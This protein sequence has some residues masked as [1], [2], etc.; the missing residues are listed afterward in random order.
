MSKLPGIPSYR[1]GDRALAATLGAL[2]EHAE[3]RSGSR[4]KPEDRGATQADIAALQ[5]QIDALT[6][7]AQKRNASDIRIDLGGGAT[8]TIPLDVLVDSL[9][10]NQKFNTAIESTA[11]AQG[12]TTNTSSDANR[13]EVALRAA[14]EELQARVLG[15]VSLADSAFELRNGKVAIKPEVLIINEF[16]TE[17][18]F[19]DIQKRLYAG[20][21]QTKINLSPDSIL[22]N[23]FTVLAIMDFIQANIDSLQAKTSTLQ[24]Q[25]G[26]LPG[27]VAS[28]QGQ[29]NSLQGEVNTKLAVAGTSL[30][31]PGTA[32]THTLS[33]SQ[34]GI[35][36]RLPAFY[37]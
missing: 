4:G 33:V 21:L 27:Q 5:R 17:E 23:G 12:A 16:G 37:P 20:T 9:L 14:I 36:V 7:P 25:V 32:F 6:A 8:G 26:S 10:T 28:V 31:G 29:I 18:I 35:T 24:G 2:V 22:F 11:A 3:V 1:T 30:G 34:N 19:L 15:N 13:V